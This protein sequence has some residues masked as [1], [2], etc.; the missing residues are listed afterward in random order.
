V[1]LV[2]P[3]NLKTSELISI[4]EIMHHVNDKNIYIFLFS[5]LKYSSSNSVKSIY[6]FLP[7]AI[8]NADV[9]II[10]PNSSVSA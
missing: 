3:I 9:Y 2:D 8:I 5:F 6:A 4:S 1:N 7:F 10:S